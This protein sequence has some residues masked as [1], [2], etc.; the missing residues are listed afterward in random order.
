MIIQ[1]NIAALNSY[2]NSQKN[3]NQLNKNLE[4]LSS[5][6]KINRA[7]DDAAGLAIS[8]GLRAIIGGTRQAENNILDGVGLIHT[9]E[10]AMQE[11]HSML[12]RS[13]QLSI[14]ASNGTYSEM[15]RKCM[16]EELDQ[17]LTEIDRVAEYTEFNGIP[18]LQGSR[19]SGV[20]GMSGS[21]GVSELTKLPAW[22]LNPDNSFG[23]GHL[24]GT[25]VTHEAYMDG[26]TYDIS[27]ASAVLDFS[28]FDGSTAKIDEL[29]GSGFNTT[30]FT[31]SQYYSVEFTKDGLGN[32]M[33]TSGRNFIFKI[34]ISGL[35]TA[36]ELVNAIITGTQGGN[37]NGHFTN[38]ENLGAGKLVVYDS[39]STGSS[40]VGTDEPGGWID[41]TYPEFD[42][43]I[44]TNPKGGKFGNGIMRAITPPPRL[45]TPTLPAAISI[46]R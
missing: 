33:E 22:V 16:Q 1:H 35:T 4:K 9:A 23:A 45:Q 31:C 37:P 12:Q 25:H 24:N 38:L 43:N 10:G 7:G 15:N 40:P 36:D 11:I 41:W 6:Y 8:E 34:D 14:A 27:H 21:G 20:S 44:R 17:L 32:T 3:K 46:C 42:V 13:Y 19:A 39:R 2:R 26:N 28:A 30:C 29:A 18:V 5:G